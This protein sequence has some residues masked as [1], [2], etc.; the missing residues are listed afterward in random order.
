[1]L[2]LGLIGR[3]LL[4]LLFGLLLGRRDGCAPSGLAAELPGVLAVATPALQFRLS[5]TVSVTGAKL[6]PLCQDA[7]S[8][9]ATTQSSSAS[10]S[11]ERVATTPFIPA[12]DS[13]DCT[14][15]YFC[16]A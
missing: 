11:P 1:M 16:P 5:S 7:F 3:R 8:E 9:L 2:G 13:S 10:E 4:L 14:S 12:S 6:S 15:E